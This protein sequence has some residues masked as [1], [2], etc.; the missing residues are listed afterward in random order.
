M[1]LS[2]LHSFQLRK[3][4]KRRLK[5]GGPGDESSSEPR[6]SPVVSKTP[7]IPVFRMFGDESGS[8]FSSEVLTTAMERKDFEDPKQHPASFFVPTH[9]HV[10]T[11]SNAATNA[12]FLPEQNPH[13]PP[14]PIIFS[15]GHHFADDDNFFSKP[16]PPGNGE[17]ASTANQSFTSND[18]EASLPK[19][20]SNFAMHQY[21]TS[22]PHD[23]QENENSMSSFTKSSSLSIHS[24]GGISNCSG[25]T[26]QDVHANDITQVDFAHGLAGTEVRDP[27]NLLA[28]TNLPNYIAENYASAMS[29]NSEMKALQVEIEALK[30]SKE[31]VE[32]ELLLKAT[33]VKQYDLYCQ[34]LVNSSLT[35]FISHSYAK[36]RICQSVETTIYM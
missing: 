23:G 12:N 6:M 16:L 22:E 33:S 27:K 21:A 17:L 7:E 5:E 8:S 13:R 32:K 30:R 35:T 10:D 26:S 1:T 9:S 2:K 34:S 3:F 31:E 15:A 4:Q 11:F 29:N 24:E 25:E 14:E 19:T 36:K 18:F 20:S 28:G